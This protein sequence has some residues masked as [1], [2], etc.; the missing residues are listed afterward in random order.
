[1]M[2]MK[3]YKI[4]IFIL[5]VVG[6]ILAYLV[7]VLYFPV[8]YPIKSLPRE[9]SIVTYGGYDSNKQVITLRHTIGDQNSAKYTLTIENGIQIQEPQF[10]QLP[11]LDDG[12]IEVD[13]EFIG[14]EAASL[15][16]VY[17]QASDLYEN[18]LLIYLDTDFNSQFIRDKD[19]YVQYDRYVHFISGGNRVIYFNKAGSSEWS[20][21]TSSPR[22]R[23]IPRYE[24]PYLVWDSKWRENEWV[25]EILSNE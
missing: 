18:G 11:K 19:N 4:M 7:K 16:K 25:K 12:T 15:T 5:C 17:N 13:L 9:L 21:V 22:L 6:V 24:E 10:Y 14:G 8:I 23:K 2:N 20:I 1:M 3:R